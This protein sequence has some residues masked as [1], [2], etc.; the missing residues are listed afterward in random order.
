MIYYSPTPS[1][2]H[3]MLGQIMWF[4][5]QAI[6][7]KFDY[8][9][10]IDEL[11]ASKRNIGFQFIFKNLIHFTDKCVL[12]ADMPPNVRTIS[13]Q[14]FHDLFIPEKTKEPEHFRNYM[15]LFTDVKIEAKSW[16][17][18]YWHDQHI[19]LQMAKD[20]AL[21]LMFPFYFCELKDLLKANESLLSKSD[22]SKPL[23]VLHM[24][25]GDCLVIHREDLSQ[26]FHHLF[27]GSL[28]RQRR[29]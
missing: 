22:D 14:E 11:I 25:L 28:Q 5:R 16:A 9:I 27:L 29:V 24:R 13:L 21:D 19:Q 7:Q 23:V 12:K 26:E 3:S 15:E 8:R 20:G 4:K 2:L 18:N 6:R 17:Q 1:G 10:V